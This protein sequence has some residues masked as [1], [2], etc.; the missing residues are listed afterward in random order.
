MKTNYQILVEEDDRWPKEISEA[1]YEKSMYK[2]IDDLRNAFYNLMDPVIS[3][4]DKV[5]DKASRYIND[6]PY[7]RKVKHRIYEIVDPKRKVK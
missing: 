6:R 7:L 2:A 4:I 3:E 1:A 5:F